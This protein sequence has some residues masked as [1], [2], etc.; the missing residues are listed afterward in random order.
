LWTSKSSDIV[1]V[2]HIFGRLFE[3]FRHISQAART[4]TPAGDDA[5]P[6]KR[7]QAPSLKQLLVPKYVTAL[8][9]YYVINL[10][11]CSD[12]MAIHRRPSLSGPLKPSTKL[13]TILKT[14]APVAVA[15][16]SSSEGGTGRLSY[17]QLTP[18]TPLGVLPTS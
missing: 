8:L 2:D 17:R 11:P 18:G 4:D 9:A 5:Q 13:M 16:V 1:V 14:T 6:S 7:A 15:T 10:D 3:A 12:I